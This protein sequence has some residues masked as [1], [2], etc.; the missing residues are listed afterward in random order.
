MDKTTL[1]KKV[2]IVAFEIAGFYIL[3]SSIFLMVNALP[4]VITEPL[5]LTPT[6]IIAI[7]GITLLLIAGSNRK[8]ITQQDIF[9]INIIRNRTLGIL[10]LCDIIYKKL[11]TIIGLLYP[12]EGD[13]LSDKTLSKA[14]SNTIIIELFNINTLQLILGILLIVFSIKKIKNVSPEIDKA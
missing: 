7:I 2:S 5:L 10:L 1:K 11:M 8:K 13:I 12:F 3:I 4:R 14:V 9:Y 6:V